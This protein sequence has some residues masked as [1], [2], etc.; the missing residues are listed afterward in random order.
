MSRVESE[1]IV[2]YD[3]GYRGKLAVERS[4]PFKVGQAG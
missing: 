2:K 1:K 3:P 4:D